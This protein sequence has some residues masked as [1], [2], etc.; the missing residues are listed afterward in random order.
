MKRKRI[1]ETRS[2]LKDADVKEQEAQRPAKRLKSSHSSNHDIDW[3][4]VP[5]MRLMPAQIAKI[6]SLRPIEQKVINPWRNGDSRHGDEMLF[7]SLV[8]PILPPLP[9]PP[10]VTKDDTCPKEP[11][12]PW[13]FLPTT[14]SFGYRDDWYDKW[15]WYSDIC[16]LQPFSF[17]PVQMPA[18]DDSAETKSVSQSR[19]DKS[20][21]WERWIGA[22]IVVRDKEFVT[23]SQQAYVGQKG[24]ILGVHNCN[25][26]PIRLDSG[27]YVKM[28][29][30]SFALL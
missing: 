7:R 27:D 29:S 19:V 2:R 10:C 11:R 17:E 21:R 13:L 14:S 15:D 18:P 1:Y 20:E 23:I 6:S 24:I 3:E 4:L 5:F 16:P 25:W 30:H 8:P 9:S 28:R 26:W 12:L 22:R